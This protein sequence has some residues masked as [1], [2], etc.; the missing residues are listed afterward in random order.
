MR[1]DSLYVV[2]DLRTAQ[3]VSIL[4]IIIA[5]VLIIYR[6]AT[7]KNPPR[8]QDKQPEPKKKQKKK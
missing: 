4:S 8:Y 2:G 3:L 5:V 1:T 6:R 7:I